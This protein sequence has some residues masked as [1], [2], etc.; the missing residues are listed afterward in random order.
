MNIKKKK[1][2]QFLI[3]PVSGLNTWNINDNHVDLES[4]LAVIADC[5]PPGEE[6]R[7]GKD[8]QFLNFNEDMSHPQCHTFNSI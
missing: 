6:A 3:F 2:K 4:E 7:G 5:T 1:C 8:L